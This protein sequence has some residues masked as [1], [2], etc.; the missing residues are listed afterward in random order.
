M[1]VVRPLAHHARIVFRRSTLLFLGC[2]FIDARERDLLPIR[3]PF[4]LANRRRLVRKHTRLPA[5]GIEDV[6]RVASAAIREKRDPRSI[7]RPSRPEIG[8][9]RKRESPIVPAIGID[10]PDIRVI[11]AT[12]EIRLRHHVRNARPIR[13]PPRRPHLRHHRIVF[14]GKRGSEKKSG[15]VQHASNRIA[16][17]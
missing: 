7:R 17:H 14:N 3:R 10:Q 16:T 8:A 4:E 1:H 9:I 15:D 12:R 11:H 6:D 13:R 2:R 5:A